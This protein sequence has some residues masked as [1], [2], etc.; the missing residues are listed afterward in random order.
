M[1]TGTEPGPLRALP[2]H[3]LRHYPLGAGSPGV[4]ARF[5]QLGADGII[6]YDMLQEQPLAPDF[7]GCCGKAMEHHGAAN[8][9]CR[10]R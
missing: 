6:T 5:S 4:A 10:Y 2:F 8:L 1:H 7:S 3:W 9:H